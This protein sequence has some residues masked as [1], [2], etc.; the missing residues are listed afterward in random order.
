MMVDNYGYTGERFDSNTGLQY[1]QARWYD[2]SIE[3]WMVPDPKG[4]D[5]GDSNLDRYVGNN[6]SNAEDPSGLQENKTLDPKYNPFRKESQLLKTPYGEAEGFWAWKTYSRGRYYNPA[7]ANAQV[8][9]V[10][11]NLTILAIPQKEGDKVVLGNH[12]VNSPGSFPNGRGALSHGLLELKNDINKPDATLYKIRLGELSK[13][14]RDKNLYGV[15]VPLG[16]VNNKMK[17]VY[18]GL[19]GVFPNDE[20]TKNAA[21][22]VQLITWKVQAA[23]GK[24]IAADIKIEETGYKREG[25]SPV[26]GKDAMRFIGNNVGGI[27]KDTRIDPNEKP[28]ARFPFRSPRP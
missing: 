19:I 8:E 23:D 12:F 26:K 10:L 1:N 20:T 14:Y 3:R 22:A 21:H 27:N 15:F 5:A 9:T 13:A 18:S 24:V 4:F 6:A 11:F 28:T 7:S 2:P 25:L 16:T 17:T